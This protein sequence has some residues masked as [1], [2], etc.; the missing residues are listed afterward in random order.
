MYTEEQ[1]IRAIKRL[2][3]NWPEGYMLFSWAGTL[4]LLKTEDIPGPDISMTISGH[5][6]YRGSYNDAIVERF[7]GIPSDGGDPD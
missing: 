1:T 4:C 5:T 6:Q 3:K 2:E 7:Q